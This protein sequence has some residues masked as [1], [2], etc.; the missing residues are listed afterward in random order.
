[1][2]IDQ[3]F[4]DLVRQAVPAATIEDG[5]SRDMASAVVDREH[6]VEVCRV[7]R[8]HADLQ[9]AFLADLTAVDRL[10]A[11]PRYEVVY[12][13]ACL[14]PAFGTGVAR[15]LRLKV[16]LM[17]DDA[18]VPT[19]CEVWPAANWAEREVYDLFGIDF[20]GHPDLRRVLL[21][22][23]W[24]GH[25]LRKDHPVQ[26]RKDTSS[27]SPMEL[28]QDQFVSNMKVAREHATRAAHAIAG[29]RDA[30]KNGD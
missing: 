14:G 17:S 26:I 20:A 18:R 15:R 25:P 29:L 6:L 24:E 11:S 21:P 5:D 4:L 8:D 30:G 13:L 28:T 10:P 2:A 1:M 27:W 7:L 12:Q 22:D 23:D 9:F 3:S 16:R 19:V